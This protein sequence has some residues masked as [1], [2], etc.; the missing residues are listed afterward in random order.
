MRGAT[1]ASPSTLGVR[2]VLV[3]MAGP[4]PG[5]GGLLLHSEDL[6]RLVQAFLGFRVLA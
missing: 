6:E 4:G 3:A 1:R 2:F 5:H